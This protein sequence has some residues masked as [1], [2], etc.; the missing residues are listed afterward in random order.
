[1]T[2]ILVSTRRGELFKFVSMFVCMYV[3]LYMYV[4]L[5]VLL[6]YDVYDGQY[7]TLHIVAGVH[8]AGRGL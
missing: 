3:Y 8:C 1:M 7:V 6:K 4:C 2:R 5:V